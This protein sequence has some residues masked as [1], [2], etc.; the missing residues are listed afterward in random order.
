MG[1][2]GGGGRNVDKY[3]IT[4]VRFSKKEKLVFRIE[5]EFGG[6][7]IILEG[8]ARKGDRRERTREITRGPR[9]FVMVPYHGTSQKFYKM[10]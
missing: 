4:H 5:G 3:L 1:L 7:A 9:L 10:S 2:L 8:M 6:L